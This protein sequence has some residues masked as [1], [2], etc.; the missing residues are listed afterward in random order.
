MMKILCVLMLASVSFMPMLSVAEKS[1]VNSDD[2][3]SVGVG[4]YDITGPAADQGMMGY[5][6]LSQKTSGIL[7]RDWARA[8]II[9]SPINHTE[10]VFVN[11]DLAMLFQG[12]QQRVLQ[13][14]H[15]R[16]GQ[17]FTAG[18]V[19]LS[20]IHQHSGAGGYSLHALYNL[21]TLGFDRRYFE[22]IC[23]GIVKAIEQAHQHMQPARIS[24]V[25]GQL[26]D[27]SVNR[28]PSAYAL[29]PLK[30]RQRYRYNYDTTMTLLRFETLQHKP[31]AMINWFPLHGT[32]LDNKNT[33]ISGD[34]KGYAAY[35][36]EH[37]PKSTGVIAAFA[38]SNAGD[39]SPNR[40]GHGGAHGIAGLRN[41]EDSGGKQYKTAERLF[42]AAGA[43][44]H[45]VHGPVDFR[46]QY[47][48]MGDVSLQ[49][50]VSHYKV[51]HTCPAAIGQSMLAGTN[52]GGG[53]GRQGV[54]DCHQMPSGLSQ[55]LCHVMTK[56]TVCQGVKPIVL[57]TNVQNPPW[58]PKVMPFSVVRVGNMAWIVNPF[59][60]TTMSGRRV[61][62]QALRQLKPFGIDRVV[63]VGYANAYG[64]YVTTPQE[65][66]AQ[67]YEGAS[68]LFGP[69]SLEAQ[70]QVYHALI[71]AMV[72]HHPAPRSAMLPQ[73]L[74]WKQ[75]S[76]Q[77]G[78]L[79][80]LPVFGRRFGDPVDQPK[81]LYH[82]GD[83][84]RV[85][86]VGAD[87][88]NN[89]RIMGTFL[90][91][92]RKVRSHWVVVATDNDWDTSFSWHRDGVAASVVRI[93]WRI[94]ANQP[95]GEYRIRYLGDAK[96]V[97]GSIKPIKGVSSV[98]QV[99]PV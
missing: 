21:T 59:E 75:E 80:D 10:V 96:P 5:A 39:V 34:N 7:Q 43:H 58:T 48:A 38:Q 82:D 1:A 64:G 3:Y 50:P 14:L 47:V 61:R 63:I 37:D 8:F 40:A 20:A 15:Q 46:Q 27:V 13:L 71:A 30:E 81:A 84:V 93:Q 73:M 66:Q 85:A 78:V 23:Q 90:Q 19:V 4:K 72:T 35:R 54:T 94:P 25:Q 32:S 95:V 6:Q 36:F 49:H 51:L 17:E 97:V 12:V 65:Y 99:K 70:M 55:W 52:D 79:F 28:S 60:L 16:Y 74:Q 67:R 62:E 86:F 11:T 44:P 9:R 18:N 76:L 22:V 57:E 91:V 88:R 42:L 24:I 92:E 29:D 77:T 31:F 41:V 98:F 68:D 83:T 26:T 87:P 69:L 53:Y 2:I 56:K 33:L 45:Y 89:Y